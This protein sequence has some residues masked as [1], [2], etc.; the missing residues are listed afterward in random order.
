MMS[1]WQ[2][3]L[4]VC[5]KL[6]IF[7][8]YRSPYLRTSYC[9]TYLLAQEPN[10]H[11]DDDDAQLHPTSIL[12]RAHLPRTDA[13]PTKPMPEP[14]GRKYLKLFAHARIRP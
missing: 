8:R 6:L 3:L 14:S 2:L 7:R 4:I 12:S 10:P 5:D 1:Q 11:V 9:L 13:Q